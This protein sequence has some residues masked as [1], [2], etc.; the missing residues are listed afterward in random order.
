MKGAAIRGFLITLILSLGWLS[1]EGQLATGLSYF[2]AASTCSGN[3][4]PA[5]A[6]NP[7]FVLGKCLHSAIAGNSVTIDELLLVILLVPLAGGL[8]GGFLLKFLSE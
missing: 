3:L 6:I 2:I 7:A 5:L 8:A 4:D 1:K